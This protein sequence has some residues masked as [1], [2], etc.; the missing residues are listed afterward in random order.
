MVILQLEDASIFD[1]PCNSNNESYVEKI[2][3]YF[4]QVLYVS[5]RRELLLFTLLC[6]K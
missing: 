6:I 3:I 2:T 4:N 5:Y 1:Y